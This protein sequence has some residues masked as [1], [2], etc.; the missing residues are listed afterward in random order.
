[1]NLDPNAVEGF[2]E[3][4]TGTT[5]NEVDVDS[6]NNQIH[7]YFWMHQMGSPGLPAMLNQS[8]WI[9]DFNVTMSPDY[10]T[11]TLAAVGGGALT[12]DNKNYLKLVCRAPGTEFSISE[13]Q[14]Q[15]PNKQMSYRLTYVRK[16]QVPSVDYRYGQMIQESDKSRKF[17]KEMAKQEKGIIAINE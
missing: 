6:K 13:N 9:L 1:M 4:M 3:F 15:G 14:A 12:C 7:M 17:A 16:D 5:L 2:S 11:V 8:A 10:K